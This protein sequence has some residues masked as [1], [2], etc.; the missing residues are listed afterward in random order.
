MIR[1]YAEIAEENELYKKIIDKQTEVLTQLITYQHKMIEVIRRKRRH[2][3]TKS[4]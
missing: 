1:T 3:T 4:K 2:D